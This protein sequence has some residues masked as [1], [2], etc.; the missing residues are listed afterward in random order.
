[1]RWVLLVCTVGCHVGL[2]LCT[3]MMEV[4]VWLAFDKVIAI[5]T[6]KQR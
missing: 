1:M 4:H 2:G 5:L 3:K 6:R